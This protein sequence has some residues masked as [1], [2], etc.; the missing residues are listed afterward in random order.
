MA[1][2]KSPC[3]E[4]S[5]YWALEK[6]IKGGTR[7]KL[8]MGY[9]LE[10]SIFA[11]NKPGNPVFP[12]KA[13]TATLPNAQHKAFIVRASEVYSTCATFKGAQQEELA[14]VRN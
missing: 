5:K 9:C 4:C 13:K 8:S 7:K 6:G 1:T 12:P 2:N 10:R 11:L 14:N 3:G